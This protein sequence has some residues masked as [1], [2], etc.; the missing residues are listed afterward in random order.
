MNGV[1]VNESLGFFLLFQYWVKIVFLYKMIIF[2]SILIP[3]IFRI[4]TKV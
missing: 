1:H 3:F 2:R 4:L